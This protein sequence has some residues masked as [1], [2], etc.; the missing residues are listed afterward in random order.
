VPICFSGAYIDISLQLN[1]LKV[2]TAERDMLRDK[3]CRLEHQLDYFKQDLRA[4]QTHLTDLASHLSKEREEAA[5]MN[6]EMIE[7]LAKLRNM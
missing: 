5:R 3:V 4:A 7:Q 2:I 6:E 1:C